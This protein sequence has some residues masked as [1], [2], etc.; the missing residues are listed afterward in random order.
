MCAMHYA[1]WQKTGDPGSVRSSRGG[2][3]TRDDCHEP[4]R[5]NGLC[6]IHYER[7]WRTGSTELTKPPVN[8]WSHFRKNVDPLDRLMARVD[9]VESG[10]WEWLGSLNPGGYGQMYLYGK[11]IGAHRA[12]FILHRGEIP[13][14]LD[15]DHLCRNRKCVNPDHLDP[16]TRSENLRRGDT[17]KWSRAKTRCDQGHAY[18]DENTYIDPRGYRGCRICRSEANTRHR[19]KRA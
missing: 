5:S 2:E 4:H 7:K 18:D 10:C 16:V 9:M 3:C 6:A 8:P 14:G 11:T 17:G 1:R 12:S 13:K 15:L 19:R